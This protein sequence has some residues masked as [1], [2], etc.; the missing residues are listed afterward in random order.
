M[1]KKLDNV[2]NTQI[3]NI[4]NP[5]HNGPL[6]ISGSLVLKDVNGELLE[7]CEELYLCRCGNSNNKPYCDG[8]HKKVKFLDEGELKKPP[9]SEADLINE[10]TVEIKVQANGPLIFRGAVS[11][12]NS[13]KQNNVLRK[14]GGLC[15]CGFSGNSPFCDGTHSKKEFK[16]D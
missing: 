12:Q 1:K 15:R 4:I 6:H 16:V 13:S 11:I 10:G 5:L 2:L 3:K 14:I 7:E 8:Q 9:A